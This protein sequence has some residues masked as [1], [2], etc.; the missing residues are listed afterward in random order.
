M[1][2]SYFPDTSLDCGTVWDILE[3]HFQMERCE[4]R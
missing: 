3:F 1:E 2:K 4:L